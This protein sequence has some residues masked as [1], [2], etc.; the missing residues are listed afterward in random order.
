MKRVK[1]AALFLI[2]CLLGGCSG[3]SIDELYCLPQAS[4][5]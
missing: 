5:D 4:E 2:V 3:M 1:C